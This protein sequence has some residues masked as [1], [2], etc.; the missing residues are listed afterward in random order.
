MLYSSNHNR[1]RLVVVL[2]VLALL[3]LVLHQLGQLQPLENVA[4]NLLQPFLGGATRIGQDA[5]S[6]T[7]GFGDVN[8]MRQRID[9][10][11]AQVNELAIDRVQVTELQK[12]NATLREQLGYKQSN[13]D[14]DLVG[15]AVLQ[16][17]PDQANVIGQD[18]TNLVQYV[19][20]DQGSADGVKE[21]M[22]VATPQGLVGRVTE[23]GTHWSK[24]L[25]ITDPSSSVNGVVQSTRATGIVEGQI[26]NLVSKDLVIKYVPQGDAIKVGD[27]I[28]TSGL[29]GTFPKRIV[30][31]QVTEVRKQ[32]IE[33]FQEAT[34]HPTVD[35]TRL[36]FVLILKKFTPSDIT[37]EPTPTPTPTVT[38]TRK[39]TV[40]PTPAQ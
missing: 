22:P 13:P 15:A 12:E 30:I 24:V 9:E 4:L 5:E 25:L 31:G 21:G 27:L 23:V 32:D 14:F 40:T 6:V 10:L 16:R 2:V 3:A 38:P 39:P 33:L 19:V 36:E 35:F 26:G 7:G 18:P 34:I 37:Q 20:V 8:A 17:N 28:L 29:G 1:S 11:Q